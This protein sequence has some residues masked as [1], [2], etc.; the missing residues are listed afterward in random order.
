MG[1]T[2]ELGITCFDTAESYAA[3]LS[4]IYIGR[5]LA[6]HEAGIKVQVHSAPKWLRQKLLDLT[7]VLV[8][9]I[10]ARSFL[11]FCND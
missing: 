11:G 2:V 3:K 8:V 5:W 9:D 6:S 1:E 10:S 7:L 4:E